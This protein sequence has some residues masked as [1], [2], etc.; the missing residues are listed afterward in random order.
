ME[1]E[2]RITEDINSREGGRRKAYYDEAGNFI[3]G[4]SGGS[5][6]GSADD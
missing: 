1:T 2:S 4:A 5:S 3:D 6:N